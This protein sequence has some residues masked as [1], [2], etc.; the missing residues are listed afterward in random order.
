MKRVNVLIVAALILSLGACGKGYQVIN[1]TSENTVVEEDLSTGN[2]LEPIV[3]PYESDL[4][5]QMDEVLNTSQVDMEIGIPEGLLGDFVADLVLS[6]AR[7]EYEQFVDISILNNGGLRAPIVKGEVTRGD[8]FELM[9]FENELVV[10]EMSAEKLM[11]MFEYIKEKSVVES[12]KSGVPVGGMRM[13]ITSESIDRVEIGIVAFDENKT[14]RVVT[15][16]YL[17][18]GG[19]QMFF[20]KDPI[21]YSNLNLKLRDSI[22][23]HIAALG[24]KGIALNLALD[25]RIYIKE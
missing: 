21:K 9:P 23:E 1:S 10:L 8:I 18:A 14:Y 15:T 12:A 16:D 17:A 4:I 11:E 2:S 3:T 6:R 24:K 5:D 22:I 19:D 25:G 7:Q 13:Q 20:F